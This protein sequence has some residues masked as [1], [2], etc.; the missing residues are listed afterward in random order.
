MGRK[1]NHACRGEIPSHLLKVFVFSFTH[2]IRGLSLGEA[3]QFVTHVF[4]Q[5]SG[6]LEKEKSSIGDQ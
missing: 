6:H 3:G 4:V 1:L 2:H 5:S